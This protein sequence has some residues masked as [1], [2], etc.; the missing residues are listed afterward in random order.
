MILRVEQRHFSLCWKS[1]ISYEKHLSRLLPIGYSQIVHNQYTFFLKGILQT[2]Q[3]ALCIKLT[4]KHKPRLSADLSPIFEWQTAILANQHS[5]TR[6]TTFLTAY[7][8]VQN[9]LLT[10]KSRSPK[11][12]GWTYPS[13]G[14]R[15]FKPRGRRKGFF[16]DLTTSVSGAV[17]LLATHKQPSDK[18]WNSS[19]SV[20]LTSVDGRQTW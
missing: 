9:D 15:T 6:Y 4:R 17:S 3:P 20:T 5:Q 8:A 18:A 10:V 1:F 14:R 13:K 2:Y 7:P 11:G 19:A 16:S 12:P